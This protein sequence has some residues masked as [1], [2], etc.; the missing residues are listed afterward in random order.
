VKNL[1]LTECDNNDLFKIE[2]TIWEK[3]I[4][5]KSKDKDLYLVK[6]VRLIK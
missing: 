4:N 3:V 5:N 2:E 6:F 1:N